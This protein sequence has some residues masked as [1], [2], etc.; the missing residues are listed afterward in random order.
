MMYT[1]WEYIYTDCMRWIKSIMQNYAVVL[2]NLLRI[3][4][5]KK[6]NKCNYILMALL[7]LINHINL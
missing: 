6:T 7:I 4:D 5:V 1:R 2:F 3:C